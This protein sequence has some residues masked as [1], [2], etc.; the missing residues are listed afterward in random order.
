MLE[1]IESLD[2][3]IEYLQ[4]VYDEKE[5]YEIIDT[6]NGKC[7]KWNDSFIQKCIQA[8]S[9]DALTQFTEEE[10]NAWNSFVNSQD[11]YSTQVELVWKSLNNVFV[12]LYNC[13]EIDNCDREKTLI[14]P[15]E[16]AE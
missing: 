2:T 16:C 5:P 8:M 3:S 11:S 14:K 4:K 6:L 7:Y 13:E 1:N 9:T 15:C 10:L 12:N